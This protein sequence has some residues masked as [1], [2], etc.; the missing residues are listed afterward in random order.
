MSAVKKKVSGLI[1]RISVAYCFLRFQEYFFLNAIPS[2]VKHCR[3]SGKFGARTLTEYAV[4]LTLSG[5]L[6]LLRLWLALIQVFV[7]RLIFL[8]ES[9]F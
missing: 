3:N 7:Q 1:L 2:D 8:T 9:V 5:L 4:T 6:P